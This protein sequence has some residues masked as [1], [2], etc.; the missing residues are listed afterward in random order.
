MRSLGAMQGQE[1]RVALWSVAQR[2]KSTD[3]ARML[4][5]FD[6]GTIL[7]THILR[8]T[9]HFVAAKDFK[10][11]IGLSGPRVDS[12]NTS[13]Y[14]QLELDEKLLVRASKV[15]AKALSGGEHLTRR[16]LGQ[17]LQR[18]RIS[19]EGQ[20]LAYFVMRA[21]LEG[22][23]CSGALRGKQHT[24]ALLDERAPKSKKLDRD[25]ALAELT[26]R[27]FTSRGPATIKDFSRWSSF[28]M[29]D[30]RSGVEA[31][32][33]ELHEEKIGDRTYWLSEGSPRPK[34]R[35]DKVVDLVQIYDE[36]VMGYSDSRDVLRPADLSEPP[37]LSTPLMHAVLLDGQLVG[38]WNPEQ[39]RGSVVVE[40][41]LYRTLNRP[42]TKA[43]RDAVERYGRYRGVPARLST[44]SRP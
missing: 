29:S 20:R 24:Y 27:Y 31:V 1:F 6:D 37:S 32:R 36:L 42:E 4:R 38:H 11:M 35:P 33:S 2:T 44:A 40:T 26:R 5:A 28:T 39:S 8:P 3:E 9:W 30:C 12:L 7:R 22:L 41:S 17:A 43:L 34:G 18:A 10:W 21:E 25:T 16:E 15:I 23:V 19:T 13:R 14:R